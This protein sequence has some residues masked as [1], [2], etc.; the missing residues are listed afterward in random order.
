MLRYKRFAALIA[1]CLS[2]ILATAALGEGID[3]GAAGEIA[4]K[5]V[6]ETVVESYEAD[7]GDTGEEGDDGADDPQPEG[8]GDASGPAVDPD[9]AAQ[10]HD[11]EDG[12]ANGGE[13][14]IDEPVVDEPVADEPVV[15]EP[16]AGDNAGGSSE[17]NA[18]GAGE[19]TGQDGNVEPQGEGGDVGQRDDVNAI[20]Q[21]G[22][23][24]EVVFGGDGFS[25]DAEVA[26]FGQS[27]ADQ[28][29]N[30]P[31][32]YG[33]TPLSSTTIS[34]INDVKFT[35]EPHEPE[36][37]VE[38]NSYTLQ[39]GKDYDVAYSDNINAGEV[40]VTITADQKSEYDG[41]VT[42]YFTMW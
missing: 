7:I 34:H 35:G 11:G 40:A 33:T 8:T 37:T 32:Q 12:P 17:P 29:V 21:I 5:N 23:P 6:D 38:Y 19:G 42:V 16:A 41:S 9:G 24:M 25:V 39:R 3:A 36:F 27:G 13:P 30:A 4:A 31:R 18:A 15:D 10:V 2:L 20:E 14:V 26:A 1:L 28:N 22:E